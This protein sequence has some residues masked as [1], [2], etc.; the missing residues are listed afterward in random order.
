[1]TMDFITL[2]LAMKSLNFFC[3]WI[4]Y[5]LF[6]LSIKMKIAAKKPRR[7][8]TSCSYGRTRKRS[9]SIRRCHWRLRPSIL[10]YSQVPHANRTAEQYRE[11]TGK[12]D[13]FIMWSWRYKIMNPMNFQKDK[14]SISRSIQVWLLTRS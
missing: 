13:W 12:I 9:L 11:L 5:T 7:W 14:Q 1:M 4:F 2:I 10:K 6:Q 3:T 8:M